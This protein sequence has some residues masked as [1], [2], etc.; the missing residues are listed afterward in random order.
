MRLHKECGKWEL[1]VE[2]HGLLGYH[3][4]DEPYHSQIITVT[5]AKPVLTPPVAGEVLF[6]ED[7]GPDVLGTPEAEA[8][9]GGE[10]HLT[11]HDS[12]PTAVDGVLKLT[13]TWD[14][15]AD[16]DTKCAVLA[17]VE[18]SI[19]LLRPVDP[20]QKASWM[21]HFNTGA[22]QG[23]GNRVIS[24]AVHGGTLRVPVPVEGRSGRVL[25]EAQLSWHA[26][27]GGSAAW[28]VQRRD[29][30]VS[31][32]HIPS[33]C[34]LARAEG[35]RVVCQHSAYDAH[36][37]AF[38]WQHTSRVS[39]GVAYLN[40]VQLLGVD[41]GRGLP[42]ASCCTHMSRWRHAT[43]KSRTSTY[44]RL[45]LLCVPPTG[46]PAA[47]PS[48]RHGALRARQRVAHSLGGRC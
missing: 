45:V 39:D 10:V 36:T 15:R 18:Q 32:L 1:F 42:S 41:G 37:H 46:H 23:S 11:F 22:G 5:P 25:Q 34:L 35:G 29:K 47:S 16:S 33:G 30:S 6:G 4:S 3:C 27:L 13:R 2:W 8:P 31:L 40:V 20:K 19:T 12:E 43:T 38:T 48:P 7:Y 44:R 17:S 28:D 9:C 26:E 14:A 24:S 21:Q